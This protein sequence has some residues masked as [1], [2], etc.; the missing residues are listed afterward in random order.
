M[1]QIFSTQS[2]R[3]YILRV[4]KLN[5]QKY[6]IFKPKKIRL[7]KDR[8]PWIMWSKC[9]PYKYLVAWQETLLEMHRNESEG[10][11]RKWKG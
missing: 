4:A 2:R 10:Q 3:I 9:D 6:V 7:C 1:F 5:K 8:C 11:K